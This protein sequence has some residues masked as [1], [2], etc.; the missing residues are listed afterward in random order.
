M[1][2]ASWPVK[3]SPPASMICSS[4]VV[5]MAPKTCDPAATNCSTSGTSEVWA[6]RAPLASCGARGRSGP[7]LVLGDGQLDELVAEDRRAVDGRADVG[8]DPHAVVERQRHLR[9]VPVERDGAHRADRHVGHLH[10]GPV[11]EIAHIG[12][13]GGRRALSPTTGDGATGE[14]QNERSEDGHCGQAATRATGGTCEARIRTTPPRRAPSPPEAHA[15][16]ARDA[17]GSDPAAA[18]ATGRQRERSGS[19]RTCVEG[20][21]DGHVPHVD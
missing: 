6:M 13:D 10:L 9:L 8:R 2:D 11:G 20:S 3:P 7:R 15:G 1:S 19:G 4:C 16:R 5:E 18:A 17:G 12:E 14:C 21:G